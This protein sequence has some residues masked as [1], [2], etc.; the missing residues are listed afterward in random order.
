M[1]EK[2]KGLTFK[3]LPVYCKILRIVTLVLLMLGTIQ[4]LIGMILTIDN[5][6][7][8][9]ITLGALG[10]LIPAIIVGIIDLNLEKKYKA[11]LDAQQPTETAPKAE[12]VKAE[13][14][15]EQ[16]KVEDAWICP[17]CG[18]KMTGKFC[19]KCGTKKTDGQA[20]AQ[21]AKPVAAAAPV[22]S[23]S[24]PVKEEPKKSK[25]GLIIGLS[26]GGGCLLLAGLIV[27]GVF[28]IK[29]IAN[30]I[31]GGGG[32]STKDSLPADYEFT[33]PY[34][35]VDYETDDTLT[36]FVFRS[37]KSIREYCWCYSNSYKSYRYYEIKEGTYVY[38]KS[39]QTIN[40]T[41]TEYQA[42]GDGWYVHNYDT[43]E[44]L[45]F[46]IKTET[47]MVYSASNIND[48]VVKKVTTFTNSTSTKY[49][50]S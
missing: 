8:W 7:L 1:A 2:K 25:K 35:T 22:A 44:K 45:T 31:N 14:P 34:G 6:Y 24:E 30:S 29:A 47:K 20:V 49:T 32:G 9:G 26:V 43:P 37:D 40:V 11:K 42:Y 50:G 41:L 18:A 3:E 13:Q 48:T 19:H 46:K 10:F 39:T 21:E 17:N 36:G 4:M 27:G 38:N 28:G 15:K 5:P 23:A 12:E 33:V 16:P